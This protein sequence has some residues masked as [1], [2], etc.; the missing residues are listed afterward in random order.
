MLGGHI[1]FFYA[2]ISLCRFILFV[3]PI[4]YLTASANSSSI[5]GNQL[6]AWIVLNCL[7][8]TKQSNFNKQVFQQISLVHTWFLQHV[9]I[10][11][12]T[13]NPDGKS[14][15]LLQFKSYTQSRKLSRIQLLADSASRFGTVRGA[16]K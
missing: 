6:K 9:W 14:S 2:I 15:H 10:T 16:R 5:I 4:M 11:M 8:V 12:H 7:L 13:S 1:S 3:Y